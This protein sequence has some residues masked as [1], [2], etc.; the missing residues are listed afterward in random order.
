MREENSVIIW[1]KFARFDLGCLKL[2]IEIP[3]IP[4]HF[5]VRIKY[6]NPD[7]QVNLGGLISS[8][9]MPANSDLVSIILLG[10]INLFG[11]LTTFWNI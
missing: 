7:C 4:N 8:L 1:L 5:S 6:A 10:T 9:Q 11:K 3:I 2:D